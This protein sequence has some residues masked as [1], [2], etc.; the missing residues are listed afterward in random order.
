MEIYLCV[1][2]DICSGELNIDVY[3]SIILLVLINSDLCLL[4]AELCY[5]SPLIK[6]SFEGQIIQVLL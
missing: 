2:L 3:I 4:Y 5:L 1:T 6:D